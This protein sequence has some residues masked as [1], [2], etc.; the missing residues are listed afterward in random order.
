MTFH[1]VKAYKGNVN[2]ETPSS[3]CDE[4]CNH[5]FPSRWPG[6][7]NVC[8]GTT[9]SRIFP[10]IMNK[11]AKLLLSKKK[12]CRARKVELLG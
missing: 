1:S 3:V 5:S 8:R 12:Y 4:I 10:L 11:A 6:N 9:F 7:I 2:F